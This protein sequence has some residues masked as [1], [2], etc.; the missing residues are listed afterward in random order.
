MNNNKYA[1]LNEDHYLKYTEEQEVKKTLQNSKK[2]FDKKN[3]KQKEIN[4][5]ELLVAKLNSELS[6]KKEIDR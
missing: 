3:K 6:N 4:D 1:F 2:T 5:N